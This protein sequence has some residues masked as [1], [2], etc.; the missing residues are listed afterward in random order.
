MKSVRYTTIAITGALLATTAPSLAQDTQQAPPRDRAVERL[1]RLL[2][3]DGDGRVGAAEVAAEQQR[4]LQAADLD[5]DGK[6][7]VAEFKRRGL[8]F[9]S[10]RT[11]SLFDLM[12]ADGDQLLTLEEIQA[13]SKR[14]LTRYDTDGDDALEASEL[15]RRPWKRPRRR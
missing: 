8:W 14:W 13:P 6:L 10:L 7:S 1:I 3:T 15:P 4:L 12:D 2:D 11:T 9:L 5:N